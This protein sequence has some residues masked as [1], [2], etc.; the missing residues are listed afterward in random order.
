MY[1]ITINAKQSLF[2][3]GKFLIHFFHVFQITLYTEIP[4]TGYEPFKGIS[5]ASTFYTRISYYL[6]SNGF[7]HEKNSLI[8]IYKDG[9]SLFLT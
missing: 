5:R 9:E 1:F 4:L 7:K 2:F 8:W 6:F 3:T